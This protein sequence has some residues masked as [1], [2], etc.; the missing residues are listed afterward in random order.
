M[1]IIGL[2]IIGCILFSG[3]LFAEVIGNIDIQ[4]GMVSLNSKNDYFYIIDHFP[5]EIWK[6]KFQAL[7]EQ[8]MQ[9]LNVGKLE[10]G[11]IDKID[12]THKV[13]KLKDENSGE[14]KERYQYEYKE[15]P[16]CRLFKLGF[17]VKEVE[18]LLGYIKIGK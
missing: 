7:L 13:I 15:D 6:P 17:T 18:D 4:Y 1:K 5:S 14:V 10:E 2:V 16:N 3:V 12:E 8:R 11:Q 9:W